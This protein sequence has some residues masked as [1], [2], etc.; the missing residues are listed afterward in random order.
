MVHLQ[1]PLMPISTRTEF[2]DITFQELHIVENLLTHQYYHE[3]RTSKKAPCIVEVPQV[4][5]TNTSDC[6]RATVMHV[7]RD[8]G[9]L[10]NCKQLTLE[11]AGAS[12]ALFYWFT[13][14]LAVFTTQSWNQTVAC[15]GSLVPRLFTHLSD[16]GSKLLPGSEFL[17]SGSFRNM[18]SLTVNALHNTCCEV[19]FI[20]QTSCSHTLHKE[21]KTTADEWSQRSTI[22]V[23]HS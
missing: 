7:L 13:L 2:N 6:I 17:C 16:R 14:H 19:V 4:P 10:C 9:K 23:L 8:R 15:S 18:D 11:L 20:Q 5:A 21:R 3:Y 1:C 12:I 22:I